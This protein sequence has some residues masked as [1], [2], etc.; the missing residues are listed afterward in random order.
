MIFETSVLTRL[1]L[2]KLRRIFIFYAR[3]VFNG[4]AVATVRKSN[5]A[6]G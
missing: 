6:D 2:V 5:A 3:Q 1:Y 4:A